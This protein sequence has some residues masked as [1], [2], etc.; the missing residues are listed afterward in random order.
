M[1]PLEVDDANPCMKCGSIQCAFCGKDVGKAF[2]GFHADIAKYIDKEG[3]VRWLDYKK[4]LDKWFP[5]V[6]N[7][8]T[9]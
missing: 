1:T 7:I 6:P 5:V 3:K 4:C 9:G 2:I 8:D